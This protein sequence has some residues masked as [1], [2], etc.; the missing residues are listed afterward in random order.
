MYANE[1]AKNNKNGAESGPGGSVWAETLWKRR[2]EAQDH[3]PSPPGPKNQIKKNKTT[4][5]HQHPDFTVQ[6]H[7]LYIET[8]DK[9]LKRLLIRYIYLK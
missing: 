8:P 1:V 2:P 7:P 9:P 6:N 5:N 4:E 3:F